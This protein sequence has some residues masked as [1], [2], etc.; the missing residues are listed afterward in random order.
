[1]KIGRKPDPD[2][3]LPWKDKII[4]S[5]CIGLGV[6]MA[7]IVF[8]YYLT[9][10]YTDVF[11]LAAAVASFVL[12]GS[13]IFDTVTDFIMGVTID[14]VTLKS[15]KY[16]GWLKIACVPM[17]IGLTLIFAPFAHMSD[18]FK[19][20][21]AILTYGTYGAIWNTMAYGPSNAMLVNMTR[22]V[23]ERATMVGFREVFYN[24]G[25][26]IVTA[27]FIPMV[28]LFGQGDESK[29]FFC[30]SIVV[31][32][33][34]FIAQLANL[35]IQRKYELH[36]DGSPR[37]IGAEKESEERK[38]SLKE[39]VKY[40]G[41]NHPAIIVLVGIFAMN[42]LM[43]VKGSLMI[44]TF[45]YYFMDEAFYSV[46][47]GFFTVAAIVGALLIQFLIKWF[48]GS[49]RAFK[50]VLVANIVMNVIYFVMCKKMGPE[51]SGAALHFGTLFV[52]FVIC[53]LLQGAHYGFPNL[54]LPSTIDYGYAKTGRLQIGLI[55]GVNSLCISL[56]SAVGGFF[57]AQVLNLI[58]YVP[59][60]MQT[61]KVMNG[62][63]TGAVLIPV[64]LMA[65]QLVLQLFYNIKDGE[66]SS[67]II[68]N[69]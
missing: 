8:S 60:V 2:G 39:E 5:G 1:M 12:L 65:I 16:R 59:N 10:F 15:G 29:G 20:F 44:Y 55:N 21:W 62:I 51:G 32:G 28:Q 14:K 7:P 3:R 53:G 43:T 61:E 49:N 52:V 23:G 50:V 45:K 48:K 11:G 57:T 13:R 47:R 41:K 34:A 22:N 18:G 19:I 36:E 25:V 66:Q 24:I 9:Y 46:A 56:A 26:V 54:L 38:Y 30:A 17:F 67:P 33:I 35:V 31:G 6:N 63:L 4:Y 42:I 27:L 69:E 64:I 58:G 37:M 68:P 40:L